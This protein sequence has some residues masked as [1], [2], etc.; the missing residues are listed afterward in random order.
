MERFYS[1]SL[2][3]GLIVLNIGITS[4]GKNHIVTVHG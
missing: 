4:S 3:F 1:I 2:L